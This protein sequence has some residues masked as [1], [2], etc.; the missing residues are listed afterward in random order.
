MIWFIR[1]AIVV[2]T[3]CA[4]YSLRDDV[5]V[6]TFMGWMVSCYA[7]LALHHTDLWIDKHL[8]TQDQDHGQQAK[9]SGGSGNG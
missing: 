3:A 6:F 9:D 7:L 2:C 5:T 8:S 1:A 4:A